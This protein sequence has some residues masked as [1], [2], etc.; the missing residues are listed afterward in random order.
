M[1]TRRLG[2]LASAFAFVAAPA[3]AQHKRRSQR[4][5]GKDK[6]AAADAAVPADTPLGP[7]RYRR[8][9]GLHSGLRHRRHAAG[10][11]GG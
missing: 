7:D 3:F 10:K 6:D 11:A 4:T 8:T 2:L 1:L 5:R 9:L